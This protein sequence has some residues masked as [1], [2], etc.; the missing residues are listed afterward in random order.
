MTDRPDF[1]F[2]AG[3]PMRLGGRDWLIPTIPHLIG[4]ELFG[5]L[6]FLAMPWAASPLVLL[7]LLGVIGAGLVTGL[8]A[9]PLWLGDPAARRAPAGRAVGHAERWQTP[10]D[11]SG[12]G[13]RWLGTALPLQ[14][15]AHGPA[16]TIDFLDADV[17]SRRIWSS[18]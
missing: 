7:V 9:A 14:L 13:S 8:V 1:P 16:N 4:E 10:G 15:T 2:Y 6:P 11:L 3:R 5:I 12:H 18:I 17:P